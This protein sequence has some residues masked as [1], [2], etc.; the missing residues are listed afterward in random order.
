MIYSRPVTE[1]IFHPNKEGKRRMCPRCGCRIHWY[2]WVAAQQLRVGER[3]HTLPPALLKSLNVLLVK[4]VHRAFAWVHSSLLFRIAQLHVISPSS[5]WCPSPSRPAPPSSRSRSAWGG[6][7][8]SHQLLTSTP[9]VFTPIWTRW[10]DLVSHNPGH[11]V[12]LGNSSLI[13]LNRV[14]DRWAG[15]NYL[16]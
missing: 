15:C 9:A 1:C 7:A 8:W 16:W 2:F 4:L 11:G 3:M 12:V 14:N 6:K 13:A 5:W 10:L